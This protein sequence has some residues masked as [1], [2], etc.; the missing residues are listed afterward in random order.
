MLEKLGNTGY[1]DIQEFLKSHIIFQYNIPKLAILSE[2][3]V[4]SPY[5]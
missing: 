2:N 4:P 5:N 3:A 1:T